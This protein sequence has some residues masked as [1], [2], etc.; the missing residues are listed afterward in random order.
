MTK[1]KMRSDSISA[2]KLIAVLEDCIEKND[3]L[4][5][6]DMDGDNE[7]AHDNDSLE[8]VIA[9]IESGDYDIPQSVEFITKE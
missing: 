9:M 1:Q 3:L 6:Q 5:E 2:R 8:N 4:I 7:C